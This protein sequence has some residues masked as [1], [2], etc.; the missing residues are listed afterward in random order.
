VRFIQQF[1]ENN[2]Y[3]H[4]I[5]GVTVSRCYRVMYDHDIVGR[6]SRSRASTST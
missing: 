5:F 3:S 2:H 6:A 4:S 1:V